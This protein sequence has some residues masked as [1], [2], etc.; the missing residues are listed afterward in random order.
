MQLELT[1]DQINATLDAEVILSAWNPTECELGELEWNYYPESVAG[2]GD[3]IADFVELHGKADDEFNLSSRLDVT[4]TAYRWNDVQS[5]KGKRR[6][7]LTVVDFG[8]RRAAI[9]T[10]EV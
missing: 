1:P 10:G 8:D 6:G 3:T 9:F 7:D 2:I 5:A 4:A